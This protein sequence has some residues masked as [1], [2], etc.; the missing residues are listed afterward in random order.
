LARSSDLSHSSQKVSMHIHVE[1]GH[2]WSAYQGRRDMY[3]ANFCNYLSIT[4]T[5]HSTSRCYLMLSPDLYLI[6]HQGLKKRELN[7]VCC[8]PVFFHL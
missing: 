7:N 3:I 8:I 2:V 5:R 4:D 6:L 1:N